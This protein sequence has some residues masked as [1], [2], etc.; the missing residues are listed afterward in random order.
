MRLHNLG[1]NQSGKQTCGV[2]K[3]VDLR[4]AGD[5]TNPAPQLEAAFENANRKRDIKN[6]TETPFYK[7]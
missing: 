5:V 3:T 1:T 4:R 6:K 7:R 2:K